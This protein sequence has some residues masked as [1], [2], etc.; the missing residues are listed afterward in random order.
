[1]VTWRSR[2]RC[3]RTSPEIIRLAVMMSIWFSM[4]LRNVEDLPHERGDDLWPKTV[5]FR[6]NRSG[7]A[8]NRQWECFKRYTYSGVFAV[9]GRGLRSGWWRGHLGK[10]FVKINGEQH[11][12]RLQAITSSLSC[13]LRQT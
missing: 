1:M 11:Y 13:H 6:W 4:S 9:T 12:P 8:I 2:F 5:R 3:F 7:S 10:M